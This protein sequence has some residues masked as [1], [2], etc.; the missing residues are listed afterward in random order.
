MNSRLARRILFVE[1]ETLLQDLFGNLLIRSNPEWRI[2][3]ATSLLMAI[4][5][6]DRAD[7][8]TIILDI[9]LPDAVP[10]VVI[11][12]VV[13]IANDADV[14]VLSGRIYEDNATY[15]QYGVTSIISKTVDPEEAS[16]KISEI[17]NAEK[18]NSADDALYRRSVQLTN[19]QKRV[20]H[21][22]INRSD[23]SIS[24]IA[25]KMGRSSFTVMRHRQDIYRAHSVNNR[26]DLTA[27]FKN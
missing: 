20:L 4:E 16:K 5:M 7:Y 21:Y 27:I 12:N 1:D 17:V 6:L 24:D 18:I 23:L 8:D 26:G 11:R 22:L 3:N 2:D 13:A 19:A 10:D 15:K 9:G 25:A 14:I